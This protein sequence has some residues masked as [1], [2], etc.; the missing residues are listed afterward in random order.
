MQDTLY[1]VDE[2]RSLGQEPLHTR[3]ARPTP[4]SQERT[5][6]PPLSGALGAARLI[7]ASAPAPGTP[8]L[9][10]ARALPCHQADVQ[11][12][13]GRPWFGTKI[14]QC[15]PN[16]CSLGVKERSGA[17]L[18]VGFDT[19]PVPGEPWKHVQMEMENLLKGGFSVRQ[20]DIDPLAAQ[21]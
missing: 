10:C 1:D 18:P 3:T 14:A 8:C 21:T 7:A 5:L 4:H 13:S 19:K 11:P 16:A 6:T 20:E 15:R 17:L 2:S 9:G 12:V